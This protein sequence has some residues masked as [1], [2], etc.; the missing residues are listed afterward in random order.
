MALNKNS[1]NEQ[2]SLRPYRPVCLSHTSF[3]LLFL[4]LSLSSITFSVPCLSTL[5]CFWILFVV[6]FSL[7]L[8][9]TLVDCSR[10]SN[11]TISLHFSYAVP[12]FSGR[13][14]N[15]SKR[16]LCLTSTTK[17]T[18]QTPPL[19]PDF[20]LRSRHPKYH[21]GPHSNPIPHPPL[22]FHSVK[23]PQSLQ[24]PRPGLLLT[25]PLP[26]SPHFTS[27]RDISRLP[28]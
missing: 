8:C 18:S 1:M 26:Y 2:P 23:A 20:H 16:Q 14:M 12:L 28:S 19:S 10:I 24:L 27:R 15:F 21:P 11:K 4:W 13:G 17:T 7:S 5:K 25:L 22:F 3:L 6:F 9:L